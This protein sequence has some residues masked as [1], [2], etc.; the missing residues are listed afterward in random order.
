M[1][2]D[3]APLLMPCLASAWCRAS[4]LHAPGTPPRSSQQ[5]ARS[6]HSICSRSVVEGSKKGLYAHNRRVIVRLSQGPDAALLRNPLT[7]FASGPGRAAGPPRS[8]RDAMCCAAAACHDA[9]VASTMRARMAPAVSI[10]SDAMPWLVVNS[11]DGDGH[12]LSALL[13]LVQIDSASRQPGKRHCSGMLS[14][15]VQSLRSA[16][17]KRGP[18]VR[19]LSD[20]ISPM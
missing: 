14:T 20:S 16:P 5:S 6:Q 11:N 1:Y 2:A 18:A 8:L 3:S 19:L 13:F 7:A 12:V 15:H 10:S 4:R 9:A 17:W